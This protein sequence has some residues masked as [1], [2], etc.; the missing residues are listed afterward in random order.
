[1]QQQQQLTL[2]PMLRTDAFLLDR[3]IGR[4][5]L[6]CKALAWELRLIRNIA[7]LA[8]RSEWVLHTA[9]LR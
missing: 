9:T 2:P 1:M 4:M 3:F 5:L 7:S 6:H 8:R